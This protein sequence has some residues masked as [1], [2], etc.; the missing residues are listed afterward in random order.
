MWDNEEIVVTG[1]NSTDL[2]GFIDEYSWQWWDNNGN[3]GSGTGKTFS[4]S[5]MGDVTLRLIVEDEFGAIGDNSINFQTEAGP[6][7]SQLMVEGQGEQVRLSW[8]WNGPNATFEIFR[9]GDSLSIISEYG[10]TD[11]PILSGPTDYTVKP[12]IDDR[13]INSGAITVEGFIVDSIDPKSNDVSTTGGLITGILFITISFGTLVM[14]F[15]DRR[16]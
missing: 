4:F 6:K 8:D 9:N 12:I 3:S 15:V 13:T 16:D 10:F 5:A 2:D 14:A 7:V 1:K 11:I